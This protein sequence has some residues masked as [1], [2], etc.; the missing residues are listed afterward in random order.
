VLD[1]K[2]QVVLVTGAGIGFGIARAFQAAGARVAVGDVRDAALKR[3]LSH[4]GEAGV[5]RAMVDVRDAGSVQRFV[6]GAERALGP[7]TMAVAN[8]GRVRPWVLIVRT[9]I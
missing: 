5:R 9:G 6:E 8:A 3:T 7:V 1:F 4:L 2:D